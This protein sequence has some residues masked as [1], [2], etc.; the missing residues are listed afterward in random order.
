MS[1]RRSTRVLLPSWTRPSQPC[2]LGPPCFFSRGSQ[3]MLHHILGLQKY[4]VYASATYVYLGLA[5]R[6][7]MTCLTVVL[8]DCHS[9]TALAADVG[10][11]QHP[12]MYAICALACKILHLHAMSLQ[13]HEHIDH[14]CRRL[15]I[16]KTTSLCMDCCIVPI[17][18]RMSAFVCV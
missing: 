11:A 14:E 12:Q 10:T 6:Q 3:V 16:L 1:W 4:G 18:F 9:A 17:L 15:Y 13:D 2:K 8:P 7:F 5:C